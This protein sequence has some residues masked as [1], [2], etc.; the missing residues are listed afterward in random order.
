M[1]KEFLI[2]GMIVCIAILARVF[3]I[4]IGR[5][6]F[7]GWFSHTYYYFVEVR[8]LLENG[9]LAYPD[10]PLLFLVYAFF[11][12]ILFYLGV[13][14]KIA[15]IDATRIIM[16]ITPALIALPVCG[17]I[18]AITGGRKLTGKH[19]LLV[20]IS[21]FLPL[22]LTHMPEFLQKNIFGLMLFA[23]LQLAVYQLLRTYSHVRLLSIFLLA[24]LILLT[25]LGTFAAAFFFFVALATSYLISEGPTK[26]SILASSSV[27]IFGAVGIASVY[28]LDIAR[29]NRVIYYAGRSISNSQIG[30]LF[31]S[32]TATEKLS[33]LAA[34]VLSALVLFLLYWLYRRSLRTLSKP[35]RVFWLANIVFI[36]LLVLP[37]LD[38]DLVVRFVLF[39]SLPAITILV[40][41]IDHLEKTWIKRTLV[42]V[43]ALVCLTT[44]FGEVMGV[45]MR[46]GNN[47]LIQ[48]EIASIQ[49][50][51]IFQVDDFVITK[52]SVNP[53][54]NWFFNTKSGLITSL[55]KS[56]FEKH[57]KIF[58]LNPIEGEQNSEA[59][60]E[61][62][63][64]STTTESE[65]YEIM[66]S[67]VLIPKGAKPILKTDNIEIFELD[68]PPADWKFDSDGNW[69]GYS[70]D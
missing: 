31:S 17:L 68:S 28:M 62:T 46:N 11:A 57:R 27:F 61:L 3:T 18:K 43:F 45:I 25:H 34:I 65:K 53:L 21:T 6:E 67:N 69:I 2:L 22:S 51:Q 4:W 30:Q 63:Q 66:R 60:E 39:A 13:D 37:I 41:L 36:Y 9:A 14:S 50:K 59:L 19:W 32:E 26:R 16:S 20:L 35:D 40:Y 24:L 1:T 12:K 54:C 55:N 7:V 47:R 10:M 33:F 52:Y 8:S 49:T 44:A 15:I 64:K 29:F 42:G 38:V 23:F 5:P 70:T 58:I 56:D 48:E